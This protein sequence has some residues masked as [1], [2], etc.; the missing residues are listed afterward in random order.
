MVCFCHGQ[1]SHPLCVFSWCWVNILK[2]SRLSLIAQGVCEEMTYEEIQEHFPEE[3]ALRDQDKYRYRY[4]KGEVSKPQQTAVVFPALSGVFVVLWYMWRTQDDICVCL[5]SCRYTYA[6]VIV[7]LLWS[8]LD[9]WV[10]T[11]HLKW[12]R[13]K[14]LCTSKRKEGQQWKCVFFPHKIT[15]K[16]NFVIA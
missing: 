1:D 7:C 4:P 5:G 3:F 11:R 6:Y 9:G 13:W 10:L 12:F 16:C 14:I 15:T 8:R 2:L